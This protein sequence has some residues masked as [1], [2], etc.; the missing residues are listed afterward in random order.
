MENFV[1]PIEILKQGGEFVASRRGRFP[2][3]PLAGFGWHQTLFDGVQD[4][5]RLDGRHVLVETKGKTGV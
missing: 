1:S 2:L 4:G 3:I 5:M